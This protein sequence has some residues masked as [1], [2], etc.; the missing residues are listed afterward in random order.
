MSDRRPR[1]VGRFD[2]SYQEGTAPWDI[3]RAQPALAAVA[4]QF[5]GR[6][7]DVGCGTGEHALL[8]AERG[9]AAL[10]LD[11]APTAIQRAEA[12]ARDRGL[13]V[14]FIVGDALNMAALGEQFDTVVDS[15]LFHVFD[16]DD[17]AEYVRSLAEVVAPGGHVFLL[18]F[19]DRQPGDWGPR[20]IRQDELR[21]SF[22]EGWR[23]EAIDAA[24]MTVTFTPQ[25]VQAWLATITRLPAP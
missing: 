13:T 9:L 19:S 11:A 18:C 12:K 17:R 4:D 16:D 15:G 10:G 3:D 24:E 22:A 8:A 14:R 23:I 25:G 1:D 2:A 6:F 5:S 20:R 21:V 7:L